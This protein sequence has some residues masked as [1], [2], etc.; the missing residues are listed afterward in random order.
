MTNEELAARA[1]SGDADAK[2]QIV[3]RFD[4]M[5]VKVAKPYIK[6]FGYDEARSVAYLGLCKAIER[7]DPNRG[8]KFSTYAFQCMKGAMWEECRNVAPVTRSG[9]E[10]ISE[11]ALDCIADVTIA[12]SA[13][14]EDAVADS[15]KS[16]IR[17][18]LTAREA[19]AM[20]ALLSGD[21]L[22]EIGEAMGVSESRAY[23]IVVQLREKAKAV[24]AL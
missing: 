9:K 18:L 14:E 3:K 8:W 21:K 7:F 17:A 11:F 15:I 6:L 12:A 23:Q 10:K 24:F 4:A 20:D 13:I 16:Q 1:K 2:N 22:R 5:V 19:Q